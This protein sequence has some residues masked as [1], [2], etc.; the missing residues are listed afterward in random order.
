LSGVNEKVRNVL[1]KSRMDE[2]IGIENICANIEE[3][4]GRAGNLVDTKEHGG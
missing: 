4:L 3:A 1:I 2:K